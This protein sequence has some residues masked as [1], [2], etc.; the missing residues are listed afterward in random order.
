MVE[1]MRIAAVVVAASGCNQ[2][3]GLHDTKLLLPDGP[4]PP[5][6]A[7]GCSGE[8]FH[9]PVPFPFATSGY[10]P[11]ESPNGLELWFDQP[12]LTPPPPESAHAQIYV[13]ARPTLADAFDAGTKAPF[14]DP[15]G[16]TAAYDPAITGD[17]LHLL[18]VTSRAGASVWEVERASPT[19]AFPSNPSPRASLGTANAI[20]ISLDGLTAY[21]S[22]GGELFVATR[23]QLM[24]D[25]TTPVDLGIAGTN[26][27]ISPDDRELFYDT[28]GQPGASIMRRVRASSADAFG[29]EELVT[30]N[31]YEP[32]ITADSRTLLLVVNSTPV[33]EQMTRSCP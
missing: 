18:Y 23:P 8:T 2:I 20:A 24:D 7:V 19:D 5:I 21:L 4:P 6:D 17:G 30:A 28:T 3:F 27:T 25:F 33:V 16:T 26:P 14:T 31:G 11:A 9:G 13:A 1:A 12:D 15:S 10:D 22:R 32:S 29:A